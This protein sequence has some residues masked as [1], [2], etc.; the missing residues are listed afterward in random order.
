MSFQTFQTNAT[1]T[2]YSSSL[3]SPL[4]IPH[5]AVVNATGIDTTDH[6]IG[7]FPYG[8][9]CVAH[10][11][12]IRSKIVQRGGEIDHKMKIRAL[13]K[14]LLELEMK[15]QRI[16]YKATTGNDAR[17]EDLNTSTFKPRCGTDV[18]NA[19]LGN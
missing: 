2:S 5:N 10:I 3:A 14:L 13:G 8:K 9:L 4:Q 18:F 17:D 11:E 19:L 6:M 12:S 1:L 15:E 7:R 16:T